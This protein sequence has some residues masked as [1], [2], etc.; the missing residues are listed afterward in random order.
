MK[1]RNT[2]KATIENVTPTLVALL[3]EFTIF[4]SHETRCRST[5][6]DSLYIRMTRPRPT[7]SVER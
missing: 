4:E 1:A 5:G 7:M 2:M 3:K 6:R